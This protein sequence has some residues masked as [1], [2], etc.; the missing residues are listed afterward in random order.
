MKNTMIHRIESDVEL[1]QPR[2]RNYKFRDAANR[3]KHGDSIF[4]PS[5]EA[6]KVPSMRAA[7]KKMRGFTATQR[8][9]TE[10]GEDGIRV[11]KAYEPDEYGY[12]DFPA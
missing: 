12:R 7:I 11:W 9:V 1:P 6:S 2:A 5:S 3:M 8:S 10:N 4:F